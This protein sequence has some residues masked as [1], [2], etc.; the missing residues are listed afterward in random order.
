[1]DGKHGCKLWPLIFSRYNTLFLKQGAD[2]NIWSDTGE[3]DIMRRF[4]LDS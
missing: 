1:M 4:I 2:E 3:Y